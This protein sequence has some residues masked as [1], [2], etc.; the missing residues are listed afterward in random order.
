MAGFVI[1]LLSQQP[2]P[3]I[4]TGP[5]RPP[6][7]SSQPQLWS[8]TFT[9]PGLPATSVSS[10][11]L[12]TPDA[13]GVGATTQPATSQTTTY[14][15]DAMLRAEH[16]QEAVGTK[17][18]VQVGP[19]IVDH[20]YLNP[21]RVTLEIAMSDAMDS[22][23]SGQYSGA[24]SKSVAAFQAFDNL[25]ASR[26]PITLATRLKQYQ[27]MWLRL[28][29]ATDT[30]LTSHAL[31]AVLYFEQIISATVVQT[32]TSSRPNQTG[33]TNEGTKAPGAISQSEQ[34]QLNSMAGVD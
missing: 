28:V 17:H 11:D 8:M 27:N 14:F 2:S 23:Q 20:V 18:P 30:N 7:W 25:Q 3:V 31:K 5:W 19:A 26:A 24:M 32:T 4:S 21:A 6:Q 15:F 22:F 29:R 1:S 9:M 16:E 10:T 34:N 13:S 33:A 12:T